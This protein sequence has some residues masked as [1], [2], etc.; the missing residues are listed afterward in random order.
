MKEFA[1]KKKFYSL[2]P[3]LPPTEVPDAAR[4]INEFT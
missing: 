4:K 2:P 1:S 3:S